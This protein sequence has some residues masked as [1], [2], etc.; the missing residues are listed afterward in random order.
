MKVVAISGSASKNSKTAKLVDI[1]LADLSLRGMETAHVR[2]RELDAAALLSGHT[3][4]SSLQELSALV[5][6]SIG[7]IVATPIYKASFSGLL[8]AS[9]DVLPQTAF[10]GK[11][12]FPI[13]T[14]GSVAHTLALDYGLRPVLQSMHPRHIVQSHFVLESLLPAADTD[15]DLG[16]PAL[17]D[18]RHHVD[19]FIDAIKTAPMW[20]RAAQL[21]LPATSSEFHSSHSSQPKPSDNFPALAGS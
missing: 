8:K 5:A 6:E 3:S 1:I 21:D 11:A 14:G 19:S 2:L 7:I 12:V 13:G 17:A 10:E 18:L 20:G 15:A 9:L 16:D 4:H